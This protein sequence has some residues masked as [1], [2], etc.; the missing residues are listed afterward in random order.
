MLIFDVSVK[1]NDRASPNVKSASSNKT[2]SGWPS[3]PKWLTSPTSPHLQPRGEVAPLGGA[4]A[5]RP[6]RTRPLT[7]VCCGR[8][9]GGQRDATVGTRRARRGVP[10]RRLVR[11]ERTRDARSVLP[12]V[13]R[14]ALRWRYWE[15]ENTRGSKIHCLKNLVII[16]RFCNTSAPFSR[17]PYCQIN[18]TDTRT[19]GC[20]NKF[21][22]NLRIWHEC[23]NWGTRLNFA[24]MKLR[25]RQ[26]SS[27]DV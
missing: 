26:T 8:G 21:R 6:N 11:V 2:R 24:C 7:A 20:W 12:E 19:N 15:H 3:E 10:D 25:P 22:A 17:C 23:G 13:T 18:D 4:P 1:K 16:R 9:A 14:R 27:L 5:G